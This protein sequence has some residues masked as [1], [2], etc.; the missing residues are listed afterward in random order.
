MIHRIGI[1]FKVLVVFACMALI[2]LVGGVWM[3]VRSD[4]A[5]GRVR[6]V[7]AESSL[8]RVVQS[9]SFVLLDVND[10]LEQYVNEE[11]V[12]KIGGIATRRAELS[13]R[14]NE[15]LAKIAQHRPDD[16]RIRDAVSKAQRS[17]ERYEGMVGQAMYKHRVRVETV[18]PISR[19][20]LLRERDEMLKEVRYLKEDL[21]FPIR[22]LQEISS[23]EHTKA[24]EAAK[25]EAGGLA[26]PV[27]FLILPAVLISALMMM[28]IAKSVVRPLAVTR[29]FLQQNG[30]DLT[31]RLEL[32]AYDEANDVAYAVNEWLTQ[33]DKE[34]R[35]FGERMNGMSTA[36][37]DLENN[38]ATFAAATQKHVREVSQAEEMFRDL[39][40]QIQNLTG[41]VQ[42][43]SKMDAPQMAQAN[44]SVALQ[45]LEKSLTELAQTNQSFATDIQS[46]LET[47]RQWQEV[48]LRFSDKTH[49]V[50]AVK[51]SV[52]GL[53]RE[54]N[55]KVGEGD[56]LA[57]DTARLAEQVRVLSLN[58]TLESLRDMHNRGGAE[59]IVEQLDGVGRGLDAAAHSIG[60]YV[61]S[62]RQRSRMADQCIQQLT[63]STTEI[64]KV[65][66]DLTG[67][68]R[69]LA[70]QMTAMHE[71]V[72][73]LTEDR[74]S[75]T[76]AF[77]RL[78]TDF[79]RHQMSMTQ[80]KE[81]LQNLSQMSKAH[82]MKLKRTTEVLDGTL[83]AG[84]QAEEVGTLQSGLANKVQSN[85]SEI[86]QTLRKYKTTKSY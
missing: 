24:I 46:L 66:V 39:Q 56:L 83:A 52:D 34:I 29:Q 68:S 11:A 10:N 22:Q 16:P 1:Q 60:A 61:R 50:G 20:V 67:K 77:E 36:L 13:K 47:E 38:A 53:I 85:L 51:G 79:E 40:T 19:E 21:Y 81:E 54:L 5:A 69:Q 35:Q 18:G 15:I 2:V 43:L 25:Q 6:S 59:R 7:E 76:R 45:D 84:R 17:F 86:L 78:Q 4:A 75:L 55:D 41:A 65:H 33:H 37:T 12:E 80:Y 27:W 72:T 23:Q 9:A 8:V 70:A 64:E 58:V 71:T 49:G 63:K 82:H 44:L 73:R 32:N 57:E 48:Q 30:Q 74:T 31:Q 28:M 3:W 14:Y 62:Y 26:G 42:G